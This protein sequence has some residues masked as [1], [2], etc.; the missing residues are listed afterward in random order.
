[1]NKINSISIL[2]AVNP[3]SLFEISACVSDIAKHP[4]EEVRE[5]FY[6]GVEHQNQVDGTNIIVKVNYSRDNKS[7]DKITFKVFEVDSNDL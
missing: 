1:M 7:I 3:Q 5:R 6:P 2:T 4:I